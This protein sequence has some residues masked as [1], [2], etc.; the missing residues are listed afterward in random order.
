MR[1]KKEPAIYIFIIKYLTKHFLNTKNHSKI[2]I[3]YSIFRKLAKLKHLIYFTQK[4]ILEILL[5]VFYLKKKIKFKNKISNTQ[6]TVLHFSTS[7]FSGGS[8]RAAYNIHTGLKK[9]KI[10]SYL[11]VKSK[12]KNENYIEIANYKMGIQWILERVYS[13][14]MK[15]NYRKFNAKL[16]VLHSFTFYSHYDIQDAIQQIRPDIV[17]LHW[18]GHDFI[19]IKDLEKIKQPIVWTTHDMWPFCSAEHITFSDIYTKGYIFEKNGFE[20]TDYWEKKKMIFR[21]LKFNLVGVSNWIT[22][23]I[24][25]SIL[26]KNKTSI[27]IPNSID[28]KVFFPRDKKLSRELFNISLNKKLILFGS[29]YKDENKGFHYIEKIIQKLEEEKIN[30]I[31]LIIFGRTKIRLNTEFVEVKNLGYIDS[32]D[33]LAQIY[34]ACDLTLIPSKIESFCLTAAESISCG[35]PVLAFDT[36]GLKDIVINHFSGQRIDLENFEDYYKN[37]KDLLFN[38]KFNIS[39]LHKFIQINFN[40]ERLTNS[41]ID[42]YQ[43]IYQL[44]VHK[45]LE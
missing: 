5:R 28:T 27:C 17:H 33:I 18:I 25:K 22:E 43:K 15:F 26:F 31:L 40:E 42:L 20:L 7:D 29:D 3:L 45:G 19:G 8:G 9:K 35:T 13:T 2:I 21:D 1:V 4:K 14:L 37:M 39:E 44:E 10:N 23:E 11:I 24:K 41:Y 30:N 6:L 38:Y 12:I 36:S 32:D 34:S 16:N